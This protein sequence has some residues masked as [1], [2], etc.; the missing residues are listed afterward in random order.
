MNVVKGI[1]TEWIMFLELFAECYISEQN[2]FN[3]EWKKN[4]NYSLKCLLQ[5]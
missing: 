2:M 5:L 1:A 4:N 3:K